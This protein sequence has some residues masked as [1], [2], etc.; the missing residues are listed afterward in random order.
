[1]PNVIPQGQTAKPN[2]IGQ[3][4]F[5]NSYLQSI[6]GSTQL[7][8][9]QRQPKAN[10]PQFY[11]VLIQPNGQESYVSSLYP[12][13]DGRECFRLDYFQ[14]DYLLCRD[15]QM[16]TISQYQ[17]NPFPQHQYKHLAR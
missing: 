4:H 1:M 9:K 7:R 5:H 10:K 11:L 6:S 8:I 15:G 16:I 14:T 2:L 17:P 3:Y 13:R 12:V